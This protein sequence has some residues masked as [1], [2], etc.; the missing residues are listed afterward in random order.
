[1]RPCC[2]RST[3]FSAAP[4]EV[5]MHVLLLIYHQCINNFYPFLDVSFLCPE[6]STS[7]LFS[8]HYIKGRP[9]SYSATFPHLNHP[10]FACGNTT[11]RKA[12]SSSTSLPPQLEPH[13][14]QDIVEGRNVKRRRTDSASVNGLSIENVPL[15]SPPSLAHTP[16]IVQEDEQMREEDTPPPPPV[17]TDVH[18]HPS[19]WYEPEP[20]R[21]FFPPPFLITIAEW[22]IGNVVTDS[23]S[24][25]DEGGEKTQTTAITVS[26]TAAAILFQPFR[27]P[28]RVGPPPISPH[29]QTLIL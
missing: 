10:W 27:V 16:V 2:C 18:M 9:M 20:D 14:D 23:N 17:T 12:L 11:K 4:R 28:L 19:S 8:L 29:P 22:N 6:P 26:P 13:L 25:S 5:L 1:M 21:M 24:S 3:Y 7:A 15:C